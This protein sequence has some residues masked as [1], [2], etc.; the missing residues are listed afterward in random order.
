MD[1]YDWDPCVYAYTQSETG[2][3]DA[4]A[5]DPL[6]GTY[7][8][9]LSITLSSATPDAI[10]RYTLNGND[11][12]ESDPVYTDPI[13][14]TS[15]TLLKAR[16]LQTGWTPSATVSGLYSIEEDPNRIIDSLALVSLYIATGGP[17]WT[18]HDNWLT[19]SLGTWYGVMMEAGRVVQLD[20]YNNNLTG[21]LPSEFGNFSQLNFLNVGYN[22]LSGPIPQELGNLSNLTTL[23]LYRNDL[24]GDLPSAIYSFDY[25]RNLNVGFNSQ[26][27]IDINAIS[28]MSQIQ[29]LILSGLNLAGT[30]P[31]GLLSLPNLGYL[32]L[33]FNAFTGEIPQEIWQLTSLDH[34][35]LGANQFTGTIPPEIGNLTNLSYLFLFNNQ[36]S[37]PIPATINQTSLRYSNLSNNSFNDLPYLN[38]L[39]NLEGLQISDNQL[40]FEDIEYNVGIPSNHFIYSPQ[41]NIGEEQSMLLD[42]GDTYNMN[43]SCGGTNNQYQWFKNYQPIPGAQSDHYYISSAVN[44]DAGDYH[45]Q[46]TNTVATDL[47]IY[48]RPIH[49][50]IY[51]PG[52]VADSLALVALYNA[53]G[54]PGWTNRDNWLTGPLSSWY[55]ITITD[56]R[57]TGVYMN[58][59]NLTG[60]IPAEIG[61]LTGLTVL[62][63]NRNQLSGT[64]PAAIGNL[65]K[66]TYCVLGENQLTGS[67]PPELFNMVNLEQLY[68]NNNHFSGAIPPG[69][70]NLTHLSVLNAESN[71]LSGALPAEMG[72]LIN[73]F[74]LYL[75]NN[76]FIGSIP[77][78]IRNL[79]NLAYMQIDNCL[80]DDL[81]VLNTLEALG[82]LYIGSNRFT[83][84]DIE[85]N[86]GLPDYFFGYAPQANIGEEQSIQLNIGDFY[87]LNVVCGGDH[88]QYQWYRN[89]QPI[90]GCSVRHL[91]NIRCN[92]G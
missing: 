21:S 7:Y 16:A 87:N 66:L 41:S 11:P 90:P 61:D 26:L 88:N 58:Q 50:S 78:G 15:T 48:S 25:L 35:K 62:N 42:I 77:S 52:I 23:D 54:G 55:G 53:A 32:D 19:G 47:T 17:D 13:A 74:A 34:L 10:I 92:T 71:Q 39:T 79:V 30:F 12:Q 24:T 83:F 49:L 3:V 89:S 81:P 75:D 86:I 76:L 63:L 20:L 85:P 73:L 33:A 38:G 67:I 82:Q 59:N 91:C 31:V 70:G 9:A 80:F 68:L 18:N 44:T 45:C 37:G 1:S 51:D 29:V 69:I 22:E 27:L 8:S 2:I 56:Q 65:I 6:P 5:F 43:V 40:T 4:P 28:S 14:I 60:L 36:L 72:N 84:E 57:V 64:I 46:V